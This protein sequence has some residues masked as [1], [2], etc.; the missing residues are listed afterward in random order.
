LS[1]EIIYGV[2]GE[3]F[4][5]RP[6]ETDKKDELYSHM[7]GGA[8]PTDHNDF[9]DIVLDMA[10]GIGVKDLINKLRENGE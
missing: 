10:D 2:A 3:L 5:V 8:L 6:P 7:W 1:P 4:L 9:L